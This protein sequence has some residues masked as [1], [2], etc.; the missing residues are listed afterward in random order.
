MAQLKGNSQLTVLQRIFYGAGES[1]ATLANTTIG[2]FF[3]FF[4]TNVVG[5]RPSLAGAVVMMGNLWD[6]ITDPFVGWLSDRS[7]NRFGRRRVWVLGSAIP[8]GISF[9]LIWGSPQGL[10]Q[11]ATF[12]YSSIF[13]MI[14]IFMITSFMVPYTTLGME[15]TGDYDERTSL[16]MWRMIFNIGLS[17]P[18]TVLPKILVDAL[19]TPRAGYA[20]MGWIIGLSIMIFPIFVAFAGK[21]RARVVDDKPFFKSFIEALRFVPFRQSMLMYIFAWLPIK[22]LMATM[23]YYFIYY[24]AA[25]EKFELVMGIMMVVATLSLPFWNYVS[26]KL[27]KRRAYI[28]GLASFTAFILV[29]L[30]PKDM[31]LPLLIPV[32]VLIGIGVSSLHIMPVAIVP[33]AIDAGISSGVAAS[34]GVWNGIVTFVQKTASALSLLL[35]GVVLDISGYDAAASV[36]GPST[37]AALKILV[38]VVPAL[39]TLAGIYVALGF[40]IGRGGAGRGQVS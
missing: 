14:Y 32:S 29:L 39:L 31:V 34:E 22:F 40:K 27:D 37:I 16:A 23:M 12:A 19:P 36:Q 17:L 11:A 38:A 2:F 20:A 18:A 8:L 10:G 33:E 13:Y 21:E 3:M 26:K 15:L 4:L 30:L 24:L 1:S 35:L 7:E 28:I 9:A 25:Q 6:A 5:L